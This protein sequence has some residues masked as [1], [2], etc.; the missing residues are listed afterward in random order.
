MRT[1][2]A[3]LAEWERDIIRQR[4]KNGLA[5]ARLDGKRVGAPPFG[6]TTED[7]RLVAQPEEQKVLADIQARH[8]AGASYAAIARWLNEAGVPP[9]LKRRNPDRDA[10]WHP[11][12]VARALRQMR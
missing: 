11:T 9:R 2:L 10:R 7:G 4:T 8:G 1:I 3:A 5:E 12:T 6:W